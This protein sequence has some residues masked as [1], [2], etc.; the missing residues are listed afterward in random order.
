MPHGFEDCKN[1]V[2]RHDYCKKYGK[3]KNCRT[4]PSNL[5]RVY[6]REKSFTEMLQ[7]KIKE[8]AAE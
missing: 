6:E 4:T 7:D 1:C 8:M 5:F 2:K 3:V